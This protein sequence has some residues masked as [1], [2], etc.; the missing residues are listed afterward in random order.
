MADCHGIEA[1]VLQVESPH[2][3]RLDR[4]VLS[5]HRRNCRRGFADLNVAA[6]LSPHVQQ[7]FSE[8]FHETP[9]SKCHGKPSFVT[10]ASQH[11]SRLALRRGY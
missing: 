3:Q 11:I 9:A 5:Q 2:Q 7:H 1:A 4:Q 10:D 8:S 6:G